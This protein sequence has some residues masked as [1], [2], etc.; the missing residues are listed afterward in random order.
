MRGLAYW[1]LAYT[2]VNP[3]ALAV[4]LADPVNEAH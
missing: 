4:M 2:G 1:D 3:S